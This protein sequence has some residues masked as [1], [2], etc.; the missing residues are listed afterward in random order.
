MLYSK[1]STARSD[2]FILFTRLST[3]LTFDLFLKLN[4]SSQ[5][6]SLLPLK[7]CSQVPGQLLTSY[8]FL[9]H[10]SL[11][12]PVKWRWITYFPPTP[13]SYCEDN[14]RHVKALHR[15]LSE[16]ALLIVPSQ[17]AGSSKMYICSG[18]CVLISP[19]RLF[20]LGEQGLGPIWFYFPV[21]WHWVS[22]IKRLQYLLNE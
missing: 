11:R 13:H 8:K 12:L 15:L 5:D 17:F 18:A 16:D 19:N 6:E 1:I 9:D 22:H 3:E 4:T 21:V 7:T 20:S 2:F 14:T 10:E